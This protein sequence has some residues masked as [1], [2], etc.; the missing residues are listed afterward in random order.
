MR[1]TTEGTV[2]PVTSLMVVSDSHLSRRT[3]EARANWDALARHLGDQQ[4]DLV[5]HLGDLTLDAPSDPGELAAARTALDG[6][7]V[8]WV[9]IP[10][11]HDIGDNPWPGSPEP[12]AINDERLERWRSAIGPDRW[13]RQVGGWV[14]IGINSQLFDSGLAAADDQ[15]DWLT[16]T[17]GTVDPDTPIVLFSH[18]PIAAAD[19]ELGAAPPYRFVPAAARGHLA[20]ILGDHR[21]AL[22]VSGHVHQYRV[23]ELDGRRHVW[24]PTSW[25]VLPDDVQPCF[26][27]KR[28]GALRIDLHADGSARATPVTPAGLRQLT[29]NKDIEDPYHR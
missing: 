20:Q 19:E 7:P 24:A 27:D 26:G 3:P 29:L 17:L 2:I 11:N 14:L 1:R 12:V 22:V 8:P 21:L 28:V 16:T 18:K 23:L 6:L 5:V 25:A 13:V 9:A 10:G 15:W 4:A